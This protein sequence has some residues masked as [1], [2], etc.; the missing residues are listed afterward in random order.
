MGGGT[1]L[2]RSQKDPRKS[3]YL[4]GK[5]PKRIGAKKKAKGKGA[6]RPTYREGSRKKGWSLSRGKGEDSSFRKKKHAWPWGRTNNGSN[7]KDIIKGKPIQKKGKN[8]NR[9]K[10]LN[11]DEARRAKAN[12][13]ARRGGKQNAGK[14]FGKGE[15]KK[16]KGSL[17]EGQGK[18]KTH[19]EE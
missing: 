8:P 13:L 3:P 2:R 18:E 7:P 11:V 19:W 10:V 17:P 16:K 12:P 15:K 9:Q 6:G 5:G 14:G 1:Q 4:K